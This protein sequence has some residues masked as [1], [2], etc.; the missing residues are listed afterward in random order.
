MSKQDA[1]VINPQVHVELIDIGANKANYFVQLEGSVARY[2]FSI[3]LEE[4]DP[5]HG[6]RFEKNVYNAMHCLQSFDP[7]WN[8]AK[9]NSIFYEHDIR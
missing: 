8:E 4:G 7:H 6:E 2:Y 9:I 1:N 3:A 5:F